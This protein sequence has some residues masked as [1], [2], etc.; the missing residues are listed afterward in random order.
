MGSHFVQQIGQIGNL[1]LARAVLD[2]GLA[3][4]KRGSHEQ[5]FGAG[6]GDLVEDNL[7]PAEAIGGGFNVAMILNDFCPPALQALDVQ[8][9]W[10]GA[11]GAA[12]GQGNTG[13]A[14]AGDQRT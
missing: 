13:P 6:D 1:G 7:S 9:D 12:S 10:A 2:Y 14:T 11:D 4:G 3:F 8:I 5:V